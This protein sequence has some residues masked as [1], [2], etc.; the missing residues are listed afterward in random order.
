MIHQV[1]RPSKEE[2]ILSDRCFLSSLAYQCEFDPEFAKTVYELH[3]QLFG[4][5]LPEKIFF[6]DIHPSVALFRKAKKDINK[7]EKKEM[8]FHEKVYEMYKSELAEYS[9][10]IDGDRRAQLIADDIAAH[11]GI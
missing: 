4:D 10:P 7:Y 3:Q 9:I 6:I 1:L 5:F 2:F 11:L 8:A